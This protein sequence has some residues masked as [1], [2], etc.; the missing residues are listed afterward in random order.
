MRLSR[1]LKAKGPPNVRATHATTLEVTKES[2]L[3]QRGDCVV[4][5]SA[6]TCLPDLGE[7]MREAARDPRAVIRLT[8]EVGSLSALVTGY[9]DPSLTWS[10]PTDIVTRTS[11]YTCP[12]T[13][14]IRADKAAV[15]L[16][17]RLVNNLRDPNV[18]ATVTIS[19]EAPD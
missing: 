1:T 2:H 11:S 5:V 13:L 7:E 8:I 9:G 14:M 10:H 18:N 4:L 15:S 19:V 12:R 3:T 16:P 17:R 6:D